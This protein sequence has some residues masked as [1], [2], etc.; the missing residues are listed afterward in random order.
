MPGEVEKMI[1]AMAS[2]IAE[3]EDEKRKNCIFNGW[4]T[5]IQLPHAR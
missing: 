1:P 5:D 4:F 3:L 2:N